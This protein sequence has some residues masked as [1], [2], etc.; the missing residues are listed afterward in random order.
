MALLEERGDSNCIDLFISKSRGG[1]GVGAINSGDNLG[2]IK[3]SGADGT[4]Q[5]NAAGMVAWTSGTIATGRV[6]ANLSFYTAPDSVSQYQERL[7]ILSAGGIKFPTLPST[8]NV[9]EC[10][11]STVYSNSAVNL[12][13]YGNGCADIRLSSNYGVKIALAGASN[14]TDEVVIQQDN[15]KNCYIKNEASQPIYFQTGSSNTTRVAI[16]HSGAAM[17]DIYGEAAQ[18]D[19]TSGARGVDLSVS[20]HQSVPVYFGTE[21]DAAQKSMYLSGYWIYLRGHVNEGIRF[22]FSQASGAPSS[23]I[24]SFKYNSATRPG[25]TTWDGFSDV[26][27][28]ENVVS[29]TNGID[30]IKKLRPVTFDW[31]NDYADS[32]GMYVMGKDEN[33]GSVA[34]KEN[35]Y[36]DV[37]KNGKY[38][39]IAQEYETVFPKD[40]RQDKYELGGT[41]IEDFKTINHDSLI[42][43]LTAA[44]KEAV[45]K[46]EVLEAKVAALEGS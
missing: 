22:T 20:G 2:T 3:F 16:R 14:N 41:E 28:K 7:R 4:R 26:R 19:S 21:H 9:I 23:S 44:L 38:G 33:G 17:I 35:G 34:K 30:T 45:A 13:R 46:I 6:P 12:Q 43:R 39:F 40:I 29:I 1:N 37:M 5:H 11:G 42:P 25:G 32:Q 10:G 8:G 18:N 31:T 36:D 15:S 24:Y 27:A